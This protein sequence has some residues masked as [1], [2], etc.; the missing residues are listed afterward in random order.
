MK[1]NVFDEILERL[2]EA[3]ALEEPEAAKRSSGRGPSVEPR[4]RVLEILRSAERPL[5]AY[6]ILRRMSL[7]AGRSIAPPTVYRAL[8][9]LVRRRLAARIESKHAFVAI[10]P[11][12][13]TSVFMICRVCGN[14][15]GIS[16]A[17]LGDLLDKHGAARGF[18]IERRSVELSGLCAT[19][20]P[21]PI[22]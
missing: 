15:T 6:E 9:F 11:E 20:R 2:D 18:A 7:R 16:D 13:R 8:E 19:C 3:P 17:R 22:L 12:Q 14:S 4:R 5:G 21:G 1:V 10:R